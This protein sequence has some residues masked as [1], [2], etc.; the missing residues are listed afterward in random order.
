[1]GS[2][3][4]VQTILKLLDS[5]DPPALLSLLS[6]LDYRNAPLCL[7]LRFSFFKID[8]TDWVWSQNHKI[9]PLNAFSII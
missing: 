8:I 6:I 7:D 9:S 3:Y 2:Y 5:S 1:M 4:V